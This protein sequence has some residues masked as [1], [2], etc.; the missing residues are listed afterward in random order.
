MMEMA[1]KSLMKSQKSSN[2]LEVTHI[3]VPRV[4]MLTNITLVR[5]RGR[6]R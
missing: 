1:E 3:R 4:T 6:N 5:C 2:L